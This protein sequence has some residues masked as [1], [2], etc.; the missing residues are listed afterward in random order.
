MRFQRLF[1]E[2]S[3]VAIASQLFVLPETV[4]RTISTFL[5]TGD[6][7]PGNLGRPTESF[8]V[9]LHEEYIIMDC[10]L[11]TPQIQLYEK[12]NH[13]LN[14]TGSAFGPLIMLHVHI[15]A[16]NKRVWSCAKHQEAWAPVGIK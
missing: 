5:T 15:Y 9:F 1:Y 3:Y 2:R 7:K 16:C 11:R 8:D 6:V 14:A 4:R 10:V 12:T 13:V